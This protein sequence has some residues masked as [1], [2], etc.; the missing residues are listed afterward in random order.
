MSYEIKNKVT[1]V[2]GANR[3]IGKSIVDSFVKQGAAKVYAGVRSLE[4]ADPLIAEYGEKIVPIRIDYN[5]PESLAIAATTANDVEVVVSNAGILQQTKVLDD[6]VIENFEK[7]LEVNVYG[8]LR[9]AKAFAPILKAN[10]G[11][12]FVQLNSVTSLKNFPDFATYCASK[13]AAY[14]FT[15]ALKKIP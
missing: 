2:T 13:A 15:Q 8:L 10:G 7:E 6:N 12:V 9:M 4:K 5:D 14:S 3:G 11:G 1:L